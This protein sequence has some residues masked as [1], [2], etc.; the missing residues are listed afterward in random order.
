MASVK[1]KPSCIPGG[2][3]KARQNADGT[4]NVYDVPIVLQAAIPVT[5]ADGEQTEYMLT[6]D[7]MDRALANSDRRYAHGRYL[8]PLH[9]NHHF[10]GRD[11]SR[12]GMFKL[13]RRGVLHYE[14]KKHAALFGTLLYLDGEAYAELRAGKLPYLS[15]EIHDVEKAEI[16][17]VALMADTVPFFRLPNLTV[18][19]EQPF[20]GAQLQRY[21][22]RLAATLSAKAGRRLAL[23]MNLNAR[24]GGQTM[25]PAKMKEAM[26]AALGAAFDAMIEPGDEM[27]GEMPLDDGAMLM[28]DPLDPAAEVAP[29]MALE[30]EAVPADTIPGPADTAPGMEPGAAEDPAA[31]MEEPIEPIAPAEQPEP[32][33]EIVEE[34]DPDAMLC[35]DP[36]ELAKGGAQMQARTAARA[37]AGTAAQLSALQRE[38]A[39]MKAELAAIK[40]DRAYE[41]RVGKARAQLDAFGITPELDKQIREYA[42]QGDAVLSAF[43]NTYTEHAEAVP[44]SAWTGEQRARAALKAEPAVAQLVANASPEVSQLAAKYAREYDE[45]KAA[46]YNLKMSKEEHVRTCLQADGH[47][48][49]GDSGPSPFAR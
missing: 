16:D 44:P 11:V 32:E 17:S 4:W 25:D 20:T 7:W 42:K 46:G 12:A 23:L 37:A 24:G 35:A 6:P 27:G 14:G 30:P 38:N 41:K 9:V 40:R 1:S 36:R 21:R 49:A 13:S 34:E 19:S 10:Q 8:A 43:V 5:T 2:D 18:G 39:S 15:A 33:A 48:V 22:G 3:Y 47:R 45:S 26:M 28:G 31:L 29:E